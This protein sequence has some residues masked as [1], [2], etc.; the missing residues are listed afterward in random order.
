[1][2]HAASPALRHTDS[3]RGLGQ[4]YAATAIVNSH[5]AARYIRT[6][7]DRTDAAIRRKLDHDLTGT[8]TL[9]LKVPVRLSLDAVLALERGSSR[10][11]PKSGER[12]TCTNFIQYG[13]S[14]GPNP[15]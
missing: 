3:R 8:R 5:G 7:A 9:H 6:T 13:S 14:Q 10:Y 4:R 2:V 15:Y 1:M 12:K 11:V